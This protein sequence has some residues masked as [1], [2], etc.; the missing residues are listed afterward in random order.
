M[1]ACLLATVT[2]VANDRIAARSSLAVATPHDA[3]RMPF[4]RAALVSVKPLSG[5]PNK[6][7]RWAGLIGQLLA[8]TAAVSLAVCPVRGTYAA[9][10]PTPAPTEGAN[11]QNPAAAAAYTAYSPGAHN[12]VGQGGCA[13]QYTDKLNSLNQSAAINNIVG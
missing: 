5:Q 12:A 2:T 13:Y 3:G 7:Q 8:T 6:A 11:V 1:K 10:L 9:N 4:R